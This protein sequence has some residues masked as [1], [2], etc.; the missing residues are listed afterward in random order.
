MTADSAIQRPAAV[1]LV[2]KVETIAGNKCG[3]AGEGYRRAER[4]RGD[5][6]RHLPWMPAV[7]SR[8]RSSLPPGA[9]SSGDLVGEGMVREGQAGEARWRSGRG[10]VGGR[11]GPVGVSEGGERC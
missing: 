4:R 1:N 10:G 5:G 9:A 8:S 3:E 7:S 2:A 6:G 11:Q